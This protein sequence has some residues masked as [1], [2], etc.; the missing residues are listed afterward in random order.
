MMMLAKN[1]ALDRQ[2]KVTLNFVGGT[3]TVN[4]SIKTE[5]KMKITNETF[6]WD[7]LAS[8]KRMWFEY[9][10]EDDRFCVNFRPHFIDGSYLGVKQEL[11]DGLYIE[12]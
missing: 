5:K 6:L 10:D 3:L 2:I 1:D 9:Y 12:K 8:D 4:T 7:Y 11:D